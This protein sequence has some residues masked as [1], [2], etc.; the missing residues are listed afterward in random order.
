MGKH[1]LAHARPVIWRLPCILR[2]VQNSSVRIR[3]VNG[4]FVR[5]TF[6]GKFSK[7]FPANKY[8]EYWETSEGSVLDRKEVQKR[9]L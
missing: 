8:R 2:V 6:L 3:N 9:Y 5:K 4:V 7:N 1:E